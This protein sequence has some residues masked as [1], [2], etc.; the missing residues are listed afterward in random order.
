[1]IDHFYFCLQNIYETQ[2]I[3]QINFVSFPRNV[4][5]IKTQLFRIC[6]S[7]AQLE[8]RRSSDARFQVTWLFL[9]TSQIAKRL[10]FLN[11]IIQWIK[12][13][14]DLNIIAP[15]WM[16]QKMILQ[17]FTNLWSIMAASDSWNI[18]FYCRCIFAQSLSNSEIKRNC[19][20]IVF[21]LTHEEWDYLKWHFSNYGLNLVQC[22]SPSKTSRLL[23]KYCTNWLW[24][25]TGPIW[26]NHRLIW[27]RYHALF[28]KE[29]VIHFNLY[30]NKFIALKFVAYYIKITQD[31]LYRNLITMK[32]NLNIVDFKRRL[33]RTLH[34]I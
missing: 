31:T 13:E 14:D 29:P 15:T 30:L 1:M 25:K 12:Y 4:N 26:S 27:K 22:Y 10:S 16:T 34:K 11:H 21:L 7:V 6:E 24:V 8:N 32:L 33:F 17:L 9:I 18:A 2:E 28:E 5:K 20:L 19:V 3:F 23:I